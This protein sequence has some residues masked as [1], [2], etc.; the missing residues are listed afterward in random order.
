[1]KKIISILMLCLSLTSCSLLPRINFDTPNTVPQSVDKSKAKDICKCEAKF[2]ENGDIIYCSKGYY[3]YD[4]GYQKQERRMTIVERIKSFINSL[5]G[6]S[7]W[8]FVALIIFVPG[9]VGGLIG[10]IIESTIGITGRALKSTI[11]GVQNARKNG[12]DLNDA[13]A[14]EQDTDIK[15]R[16]KKIKDKMGI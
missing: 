9:L 3:S 16:V 14:N 11:K 8:I 10:K 7:F 6:W 15:K 1:M 13:L 5:I 2:N 12:K 4:E